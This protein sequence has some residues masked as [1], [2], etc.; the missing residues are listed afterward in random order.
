M[1]LVYMSPY[2]P[3]LMQDEQLATPAADKERPQSVTETQ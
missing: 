3:D 2:L 1:V